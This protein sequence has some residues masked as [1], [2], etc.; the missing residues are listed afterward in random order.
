MNLLS[1]QYWFD[2]RPEALVPAAQ[3]LFVWFLAALAALSLIAF[4]VKTKASVY[5]GF[6]K[7]LYSFGLSNLIIGLLFL[8]L[9]YESVPFLSAR[10]WLG[11][12]ALI[13]LAWLL[14]ILN[15]LRAIPKQKKEREQEEERNKYLP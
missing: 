3:N 9:N 7:R 14:M 8:F 13:M 1:L 10:F 11:L 12:W 4:I 2:L 5:R 6:A 15:G